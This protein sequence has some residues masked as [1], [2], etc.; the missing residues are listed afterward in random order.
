MFWANKVRQESRFT[1]SQ[2]EQIY[3]AM[4]SEFEKRGCAQLNI[5]PNAGY[6]G[7]SYDQYYGGFKV[8]PDYLVDVLNLLQRNGFTWTFIN[9]TMYMIQVPEDLLLVP[10]KFHW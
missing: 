4:R 10:T 8:H 7:F 2:Q 6:Q 1:A 5:D 3:Q 9:P